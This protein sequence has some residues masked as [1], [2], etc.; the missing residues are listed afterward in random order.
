MIRSRRRGEK[1]KQSVPVSKRNMYKMRKCFKDTN[2]NAL[3]REIETMLYTLNTSSSTT[4]AVP[5][6]HPSHVSSRPYSAY[7]ADAGH[8]GAAAD[9][10]VARFGVAVFDAAVSGADHKPQRSQRSAAGNTCFAAD[11][12]AAAQQA[13]KPATGPSRATETWLW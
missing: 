10:L 6:R 1:R 3:Q 12:V 7:E 8:A 4:P 13:T 5:H 9:T 11:V 2:A